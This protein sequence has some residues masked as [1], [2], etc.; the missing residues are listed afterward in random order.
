MIFGAKY[1]LTLGL[2]SCLA[3][4]PL[5]ANASELRLKPS[6]RWQMDYSPDS[7]NLARSF[8]E[9]EN[10]IILM[11]ER[12]SPNDI[13]SLSLAGPMLK[14]MVSSGDIV[15]QFGPIEEEQ[16]R[17]YK[18]G[19]LDDKMPIV[20][21]GKMSIASQTKTERL[22]HEK[23]M[24]RNDYVF[25][26]PEPL[27]PSRAAAITN[28]SFGKP[29]KNKLILETGSLKTGFAALEKCTDELLSHWGIDVPEHKKLKTKV[30]PIGSPGNWVTFADYPK[31]MLAIGGQSIIY[32]RLNVD[33][34]G[35]TTACNIQKSTKLKDF[36]DVVCRSMMT[37]AKFEPAISAAGL[38]I[39]SYFIGSVVYAMPK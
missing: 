5:N 8:G 6:S 26:E 11:M 28:I 30:K 27:D 39:A 7:C 22:E 13:F 29:L 38:P 24:R 2:M 21:L 33:A 32:F 34:T 15:Y 17:S 9:S 18:L 3:G 16:E 14:K 10:R 4:L 37:K 36:D 12:F 35:K 1:V 20:L 23:R 25:T 19:F 31:K